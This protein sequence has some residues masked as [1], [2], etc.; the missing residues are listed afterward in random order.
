MKDFFKMVVEETSSYSFYTPPVK[1][2]FIKNEVLL[3][4]TKEDSIKIL[5]KAY[6]SKKEVKK[7]KCIYSKEASTHTRLQKKLQEVILIKS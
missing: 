2:N 5:L 4:I 1:E 3:N 7:N 6:F